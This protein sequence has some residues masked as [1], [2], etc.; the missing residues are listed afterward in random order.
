MSKEKKFICKDG[1]S[2]WYLVPESGG[3]FLTPPGHATQ[4]YSIQE[5]RGSH[6]C[7]FYSLE[8]A[9]NETW[10]PLGVKVIAKRLLIKYPGDVKDETWIKQVYTYMRHC[11]E[12]P[13][14]DQF[15][16]GK[17]WGNEDK[18]KDMPPEWHK[19]YQYIKEY[20][21]THTPRLD[22]F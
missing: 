17:F 2:N 9:V 6:L 22:L 10:I 11:Y 16:F 5:F 1:A 4:K 3:S 19:A 15:T 14:G 8:S 7:W 21:E 12:S 13:E 20:D 18:E